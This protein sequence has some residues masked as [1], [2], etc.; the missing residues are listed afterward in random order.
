MRIFNKKFLF[1][2][3]GISHLHSLTLHIGY[4]TV[5]FTDILPSTW[6][7]KIRP[8][9][10]VWFFVLTKSATVFKTTAMKDFHRYYLSCDLLKR[11]HGTLLSIAFYSSEIA[12][13][14]QPAAQAP[15]LMQVSASMM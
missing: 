10:N 15:Q 13:T 14:G 9:R 4:N 12:E 1:Y 2:Q 11:V 3:T 8:L 6:Q 5:H 7:K